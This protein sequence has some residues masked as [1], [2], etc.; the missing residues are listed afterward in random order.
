VK[1]IQGVSASVGPAAVPLVF[2]LI[3]KGLKADPKDKEGKAARDLIAL[4]VLQVK[5]KV[6][7]R[8]VHG[9]R[10]AILPGYNQVS[11]PEELT[12]AVGGDGE[13][14]TLAFWMDPLTCE[15]TMQ[16]RLVMWKYNPDLT[17]KEQ[18]HDVGK[19]VCL[20]RKGLDRMQ[21]KIENVPLD[22]SRDVEQACSYFDET[23]KRCVKFLMTTLREH[24]PSTHSPRNIKS[25]FTDVFGED[26]LK[27][28]LRTRAEKCLD[29]KQLTR[30]QEIKIDQE[31]LPLVIQNYTDNKP[32]VDSDIAEL[33]GVSQPLIDRTEMPPHR[34]RCCLVNGLAQ[35]TVRKLQL[36]RDA[37][38]RADRF[39]WKR[40]DDARK[41][42]EQEEQ[43]LATL[44]RNR[45][46]LFGP[47]LRKEAE[48]HN[49][50]LRTVLKISKASKTPSRSCYNCHMKED[51]F[52][53][54]FG[55]EIEAP[56]T[57]AQ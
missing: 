28:S 56:H 2:I 22:I 3:R 31:I 47:T 46:N 36:E 34:Q 45:Q 51:V 54:E 30:D 38:Y 1:Y 29:W 7:E 48:L 42:C 16:Q 27:P 50:R 39:E 9:I 8:F 13:Q 11:I 41:M 26:V 57:S 10:N 18:A 20:I 40:I 37:R 24:L 14:K 33:M 15:R 19:M 17:S 4:R 23:K 25:S 43:A 6:M 32:F 5:Q 12:F 21:M 44:I 53:T 55:V 52:N 35:T 49:R